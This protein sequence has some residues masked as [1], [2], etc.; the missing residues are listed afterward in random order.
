MVK[1]NQRVQR[2][3]SSAWVAVVA[4]VVAAAWWYPTVRD[5]WLL[6]K[7]DE[8]GA[9]GSSPFRGGFGSGGGQRGTPVSVAKADR[10]STRLNSSH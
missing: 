5:T 6:P 4:L 8:T 2:S 9:S 1:E 3:S 7:S 10:K